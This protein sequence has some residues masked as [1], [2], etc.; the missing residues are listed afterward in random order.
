M[1]HDF[2]LGEH[3][4]SAV[5]LHL[6]ELSQTVY[7]GAHGLEISKHSAEPTCVDVVHAYAGSFFADSVGSLL[8]GSDEEYCLAV[9]GELAYKIVCLFKFFDR[10]LKVDDVDAVTFAVN[11]LGHLGVPAPGLVTEVDTGFKQLFHGNY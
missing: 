4:E 11:V 1:L 9:F 7:T 3:V 10:L 8:L 6:F 5:F 2:L